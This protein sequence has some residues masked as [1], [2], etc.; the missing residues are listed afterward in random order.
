VDSSSDIFG[1][2]KNSAGAAGRVVIGDVIEGILAKGYTQEDVD[3]C[4]IEYQQLGMWTLTV[5]AD[6]LTITFGR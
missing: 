3:E 2:I 6:K 4:L 5:S 1:F